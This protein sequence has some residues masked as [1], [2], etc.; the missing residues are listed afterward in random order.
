[1]MSFGSAGI[2]F[3]KAPETAHAANCPAQQPIHP[4]ICLLAAELWSGMAGADRSRALP[5]EVAKRLWGATRR[6][7]ANQLAEIDRR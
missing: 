1:M 3:A 5:E 7:L 2:P 4:S 6:G